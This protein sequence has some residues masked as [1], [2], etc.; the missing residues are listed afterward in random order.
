VRALARDDVA[1]SAPPNEFSIV[2]AGG[3]QSTR[4]RIAQAL[5]LLSGATTHSG[6]SIRDLL[7]SETGV[8]RLVVAHCD[9]ASPEDL[10]VFKQLKCASPELLIVSVCGSADSRT[11]RRL[12][13]SGVD[14]LVFIDQIDAALVPTVAAVLAGQ[15]VVPRNLRVSVHKPALSSRERQIL[16]MVVRGLSNREIS[17]QMFLAES[18]VKSHLSSSYSKLGVRSRNE[19]IALILD[20]NGPLRREIIAVAPNAGLRAAP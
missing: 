8:H 9:R 4:S 15:M 14:G 18:T 16:G 3:P 12:I 13:D 6:P 5:G 20:P 19:A 2:L 11:V 7:G 17:S 10:A 1:E